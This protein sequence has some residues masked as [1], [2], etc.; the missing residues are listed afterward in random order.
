[1][2]ATSHIHLQAVHLAGPG[3]RATI[4]TPMLRHGWAQDVGQARPFLR[5]PGSTATLNRRS[6][7][8]L[9][10]TRPVRLQQA[11]VAAASRPGTTGSSRSRR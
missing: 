8:G 2:T 9:R 1:M 7:A 11:P 5:A 4:T 3:D 10:F 6:A